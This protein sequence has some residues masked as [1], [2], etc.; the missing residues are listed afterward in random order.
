MMRRKNTASI[1]LF[2]AVFGFCFFSAAGVYAGGSGDQVLDENRIVT[3]WT[4]DSFISEWG[5]G[6]EIKRRFEEETG[7]IVNLESQGDS[8]E[9]LSRLLLEGA[10]A[11]ADIILGIDQNMMDR[12]IGSGLL[13][14]YVPAGAE[15]IL[16]EVLVDEQYRL[17]PMDYSYFAFVYDSEAIPVPPSSLEDLTLPQF[18]G[19][20]ILMDPRTSSPGLGF[21]AWTKEVYG[22][23]WKDYWRR[24][25]QSILTVAEGWSSG[26]GLF[27]SGEAPLVLSYTTSPGYH[28]EYE[29]TERYK[30]ALFTEGH[31]IQVE[32]AGILA[33]APHKANARRFMDFMVSE[34]F[35][36]VIP[37]TNWMY[38]VIDMPL[39][40]SFRINPK[41][42]RSFMP[43]PVS[44]QD[45]NEWVSVM[46]ETAGR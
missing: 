35:Q 20:V 37:T 11:K 5:P 32:V 30:T 28:L 21:L 40:D 25:R 46:T 39:P 15:R 13:E 9:I 36:E 42:S 14:A 10:A 2:L 33:A 7:L 31:P 23:A 45:L 1:G 6:P 26:Y 4:Y 44:A 12:A 17:I 24:L 22:S 19:K 34:A 27:T 29:G 43:A 3:V 18:A 16:P 38:P 41:S 8:G